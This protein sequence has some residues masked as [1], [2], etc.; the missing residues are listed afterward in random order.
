MD[1]KQQHYLAVY[2]SSVVIEIR[3]A[4]GEKIETHK[5]PNNDK[6]IIW[7]L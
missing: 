2:I 3:V 1:N 5:P 6:R 7:G 4:I